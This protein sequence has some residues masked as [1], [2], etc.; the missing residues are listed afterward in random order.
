MRPPVA[1]ADLI[2][3][4]M[5]T[6][7]QPFGSWQDAA[8]SAQMMPCEC[9]AC[10]FIRAARAAHGAQRLEAETKSRILLREWL[11]PEQLAQY[12][13]NQ[14]FEVVGSN[15]G[16]RYLIQEGQQQNVFELEPPF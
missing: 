16:K 14:C 6:L 1:A 9:D 10:I 3:R 7:S 8:D 15:T 12:T 5:R 11:S 4:M 13:R 2:S